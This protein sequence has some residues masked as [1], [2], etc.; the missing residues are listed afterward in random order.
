[1]T[2]DSPQGR[3]L[4]AYS[5]L[6]T[7]LQLFVIGRGI[8]KAKAWEARLPTAKVALHIFKTHFHY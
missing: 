5:C 4:G 7:L 1:M 2:P 8:D 3:Q 6:S